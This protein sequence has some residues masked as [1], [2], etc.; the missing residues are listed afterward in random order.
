M[1]SRAFSHDSIFI[2]DGRTESEQTVQAM[3]Q[4]NVLGKVKTLQ[5]RNYKEGRGVELHLKCGGKCSLESQN[6]LSM[7][8]V[9]LRVQWPR[10]CFSAM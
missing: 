1:G 8:K 2:P 10:G 3:S 6:M 5:V 9:G 4:E 7:N